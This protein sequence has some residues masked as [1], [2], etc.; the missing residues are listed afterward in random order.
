MS[1]G[2]ICRS[3]CVSWRTESSQRQ[4]VLIEAFTSMRTCHLLASHGLLARPVAID[5]WRSV[6]ASRP[7]PYGLSAQACPL[8]P[9][10]LVNPRPRGFETL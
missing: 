8:Q 6:R 10:A 3:K 9:V 1:T 5:A 7:P 4:E 2:W